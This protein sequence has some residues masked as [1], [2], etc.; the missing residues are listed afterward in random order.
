MTSNDTVT[1]SFWPVNIKLCR[2]Y[3][4]SAVAASSAKTILI[5][6]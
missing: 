2:V 6:I 3:A 5:V 4:E 1:G